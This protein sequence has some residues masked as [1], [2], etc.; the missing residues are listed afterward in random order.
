MHRD[1]KTEVTYGFKKIKLSRR[2]MRDVVMRGPQN[3]LLTAQDDDEAHCKLADLGLSCYVSAPDGMKHKRAGTERYMAPEMLAKKPYTFTSD[4]FSLG[5]VFYEIV[6]G[7]GRY[8]NFTITRESEAEAFAKM[9]DGRCKDI[10]IA[11][12]TA[13]PEKRPHAK[14]LISQA[15]TLKAA[16]PGTHGAV[17]RFYLYLALQPPAVVAGSMPTYFAFGQQMA[18]LKS[19][20]VA[21]RTSW[22]GADRFPNCLSDAESDV[23]R[24][25]LRAGRVN[26]LCWGAHGLGW[27]CGTS[28]TL[29]EIVNAVQKAPQRP[30]AAIVCLA[31]GP[32]K[33]ARRLFEAGIKTVLWIKSDVYSN[34]GRGFIDDIKFSHDIIQSASALAASFAAVSGEPT[35]E[36]A[37]WELPTDGRRCGLLKQFEGGRVAEWG[38]A[39]SARGAWLHTKSQ[40]AI[41]KDEQASIAFVPE[42]ILLACDIKHVT[43]IKRSLDDASSAQQQLLLLVHCEEETPFVRSRAVVLELCRSLYCGE[44]GTRAFQLIFRVAGEDD[45]TRLLDDTAIARVPWP[46][47]ALVWVDDEAPSDA[48]ERLVTI[49]SRLKNGRLAIIFTGKYDPE[50]V[51]ETTQMEVQE[52]QIG[53]V[54]GVPGATADKLHDEIKFRI[55]SK[56]GSPIDALEVVGMKPLRAALEETVH[57]VAG[58][59]F[60]D[61]NSIMIRLC[62]SD[63]AFLH[64]LRDRILTGEFAVDLDAALRAASDGNLDGMK[65]FLDMTHFVERYEDSILSLNSLTP[66]QTKKLAECQNAGTRHLHIRA[67]VRS[68]ANPTS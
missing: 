30:E 36:P 62:I 16:A 13:A 1:I 29:E 51:S 26:I 25:D 12:L 17:T 2:M 27:G 20:L 57:G 8:D 40:T 64:Q 48:L 47:N 9:P 39:P 54:D 34:Q 61:D 46:H 35:G 56:S 4:V 11:A 28:I 67:P 6:S 18:V 37:A 38:T 22:L 65:I 45:L 55:E 50:Q 15:A 31:Y 5:M 53:E 63:I 44:V 68:S 3:I 23:V 42:P 52:Y 24:A 41:T 59:Y 33:A 60:D 19:S 32:R 43:A 49:T 58:V 10:T 21:A 7:A 66:H 14:D